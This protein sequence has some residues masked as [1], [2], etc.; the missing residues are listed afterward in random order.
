[1]EM[2]KARDMADR[3]EIFLRGL[4]RRSAAEAARLG[5]TVTTFQNERGRPLRRPLDGQKKS[6]LMGNRHGG[7]SP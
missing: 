7:E 6:P 2:A 4:K 1:M 5:P 3:I